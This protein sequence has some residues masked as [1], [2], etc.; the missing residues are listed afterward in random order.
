MAR[1]G[2]L[3]GERLGDKLEPGKHAFLAF[4]FRL[5]TT[6]AQRPCTCDPPPAV[7][8]T[9]FYQQE[10]DDAGTGIRSVDE[11]N[12]SDHQDADGI[13]RQLVENLQTSGWSPVEL[14]VSELL[15][16]RT[17]RDDCPPILRSH[18]TWKENLVE[19]FESEHIASKVA[20]KAV[21]YRAAESGAP[22]TV[23]PKQSWETC[24]CTCSQDK[25][26]DRRDTRSAT[27]ANRMQEWAVVLHSVAVTIRRILQ[28]PKN[29]LLQEDPCDPK[30][31]HYTDTNGEA[32][33]CC[34]DLL[35]AF[36]YDTAADKS[37]IPVSSPVTSMGSNVHTDW[38]SFTVVWQ[39]D[40]GGLQTYCHAC[41][42]WV[43]VAANA[44]SKCNVI[45]FVVHI[46]DVTSLAMG[47]AMQ[48]TSGGQD[49][50]AAGGGRVVWPSPRHRVLSP[51]AHQRG[52]LVYFAYPPPDKSIQAITVKLAKWIYQQARLASL[53]PVCVPY[54]DYYL[55]RNQS[56]ISAVP[57]RQQYDAIVDRPLKF[58][59]DEKWEQV[60][61]S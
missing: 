23:E 58:V 25:A 59:L 46:G 2:V 42:R 36:F 45:R 14:N 5:P 47:H 17:N 49:T 19:L 4:D 16:S 22:G 55:L 37:D 51:T 3:T 53:G 7:D 6:M 44:S 32:L 30:N 11:P 9:R 24:R 28:L 31:R 35:R 38:G 12:D 41:D 15:D 60:Q 54:D 29:L 61:R 10:S 56:S 34:T 20:S 18:A 27:V 8:L 40:I 52:S 21:I 26:D 33:Q 13:R 43:D 39:D 57:A 1:N 48:T 50:V